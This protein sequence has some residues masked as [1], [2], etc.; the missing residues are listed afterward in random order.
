MP[1]EEREEHMKSVLMELYDGWVFPAEQFYP[2]SKEHKKMLDRFCR[3]SE[4]FTDKLS[5]LDPPLYEEFSRVMNE[6]MDLS[7]ADLAE[8]FVDGFRLGARILIDVFQ[9][10]LMEGERGS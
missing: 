5:R 2:R 7:A 6:Y 8:M 9:A 10:E 1:D 3:H 4:A